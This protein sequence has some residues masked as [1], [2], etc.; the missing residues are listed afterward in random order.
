MIRS[1]RK[2]GTMAGRA[3]ISAV[4]LA[5]V[6]ACGDSEGG[7]ETTAGNDEAGNPFEGESI[8][9][10]V[11]YDPGGGYDT[12]ARLIAP[13]LGD[14]LGARVTVLNEPG[15]GGILATNQTASSPADGTRIQILDMI[16]VSAAQIA[17]SEGVNFDLGEFSWIG[18]I[19][20]PP[21]V[22]LTDGDG[23]MTSFQGLADA[24]EAQFV[25]TGLGGSEYIAAA[26]LSQAYEIPSTI[27]TG[28]PGSPDATNTV[29]AGD[30]DAHVMPY[31]SVLRFFESG[32]GA[33][34]AVLSDELP[35]YMPEAPLIGEFEPQ[36]E[37][38]QELVDQLI[39][40]ADTGRAVGA[41]PG[42]PEDRLAA[43]RDGFACA[44]ENEEL[45][46]E[47]DTQERP[48]D[49]LGGEEYAQLVDEV[50]DPT[51]EFRT[52]VEESF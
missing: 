22:V 19:A 40:L 36:S 24:S 8:D 3:G 11:P 33:P 31:D 27:A 10:V 42:V 7:G 15:A 37:N 18:R 20:A 38:G 45:V 6:V 46:A 34:A 17:G 26:V 29:I 12:Y 23:D 47:F 9:F 35:Q 14:C 30:A 41:P 52:V 49:F 43:L 50:L 25:A 21:L 48:V 44:M 28:F 2:I 1:G 51:A 13:Y 32:D 39:T 16:G 5:T 4:L